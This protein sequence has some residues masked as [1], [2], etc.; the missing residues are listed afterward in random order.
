MKSS[1]IWG[2]DPLAFLIDPI[3][4]DKFLKDYHERKHLLCSR[5]EPDRYS[6]LLSIE[7]IDEIISDSE[8]PAAALQ[9]A[10]SNPPIKR[11]DFSFSNGNIDRG[12]VVRH[13]QQGATVILPQMHFADG[14]LFDFCHHMEMQFSTG[15][16]TNI[17]LTPPGQQGFNTH[18]DDHDVFVIQIQGEKRW[19]LFDKP[20]DNPYRG[21][22]FHPS[23]FKPGDVKEEF[24]L[25]AGDCVYVPR[26]LMHD[27]QNS[28]EE[29]SLHITIGTL[30]KTWADF[31]LEAISSVALREPEFRKSLPPGYAL[32]SFDTTDSER[33]F[34][35]LVKTFSEKVEFEEIFE[36]FSDNFIRS[37]GAIVRGGIIN[38]SRK[39]EAGDAFIRR[40][41]C[42]YRIKEDDG[43]LSVICA[44]GEVNFSMSAE[45][46]LELALSGEAFTIAE[47]KETSNKDAQDV[48]KKLIA[49]GLIETVQ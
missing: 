38:G 30:V 49:F 43:E 7:R 45:S 33:Y 13:Y 21:E 37:Q 31:M 14:T 44:G 6:K 1:L 34:R 29:P 19:R 4:S 35:K 17:Y 3:P 47:F 36:M 39:I 9:M 23:K 5:N 32:D 22:G 11:Q 46:D 27:A 26:G 18:Y 16:Q 15:V 42:L 28:G 10:R 40:P 41:H 2:D 48:I 8:L 25:K 20:L 12:A 24:V